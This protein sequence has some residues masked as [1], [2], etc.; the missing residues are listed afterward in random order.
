MLHTSCKDPVLTFMSGNRSAHHVNE[1]VC[2]TEVV[3]ERIAPSTALIRS[4]YKPCNVLQGTNRQTHLS[5]LADT[6][7]ACSQQL[8]MKGLW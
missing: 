4:W 8:G 7:F 1:Y 3:E 5:M 6:T 2:V